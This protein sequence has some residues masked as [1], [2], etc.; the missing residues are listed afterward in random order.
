MVAQLAGPVA[1]VYPLKACL[2]W[3]SSEGFQLPVASKSDIVSTMPTD[4][5][6]S[7]CPRKD[8]SRYEGLMDCPDARFLRLVTPHSHSSSETNT[9]P[10]QHFNAQL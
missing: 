7:A 2:P 6:L 3:A 4:L 10:F 8:A 5:R 1:I 9:P